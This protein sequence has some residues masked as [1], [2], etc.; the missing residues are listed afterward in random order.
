MKYSRQRNLI[1]NIVKET[2]CHPTA[3]W[4]YRQAQ[5]VIPSIGIATVYRN[6]NALCDAGDICR[7]A[8]EDGTDRFDGKTARHF[9]MRCSGCGRLTDLHEKRPGDLASLEEA[10][11][12]TFDVKDGD[13]V[14]HTT[15]LTGLCSECMRR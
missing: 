5:A 11:R 3:E 10:V 4:V 9:H 13:A 14:L 8:G 2:H 1:L 6:L 7:I 12:Q 15:L